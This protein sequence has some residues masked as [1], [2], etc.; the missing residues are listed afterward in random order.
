MNGF[1]H[2]MSAVIPNENIWYPSV[3]QIIIMW[4]ATI[5]KYIHFNHI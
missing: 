1:V 4:H 2:Y 5:A 3:L